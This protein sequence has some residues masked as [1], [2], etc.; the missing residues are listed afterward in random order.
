MTHF[1]VGIIAIAHCPA[2]I[3]F[4]VI[5]FSAGFPEENRLPANNGNTAT[6]VVQM[7]WLVFFFL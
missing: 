2:D 1:V 7:R 3:E 4:P 6:W 5:R